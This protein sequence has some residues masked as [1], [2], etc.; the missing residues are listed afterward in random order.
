MPTFNKLN[1]QCLIINSSAAM[2]DYEHSA[3]P[4]FQNYIQIQYHE[5]CSST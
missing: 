1:E 3:L 4:R 2:T 5:V